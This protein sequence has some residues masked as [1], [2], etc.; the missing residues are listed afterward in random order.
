MKGEKAPE[1][2]SRGLLG[3]K[4]FGFELPIYSTSTA[5]IIDNS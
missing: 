2:K 5:F 3:L 4:R 1:Q